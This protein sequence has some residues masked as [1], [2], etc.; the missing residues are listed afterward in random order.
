MKT[1]LTYTEMKQ[2]KAQAY[3]AYKARKK[4]AYDAF[5]LQ[6]EA[7]WVACRQG[8]ITDQMWDALIK[9]LES[10]VKEVNEA[11]GYRPIDLA[12]RFQS[13]RQRAQQL[14]A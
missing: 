10:L 14:V 3:A 2:I 8:K 11:Y 13:F 6:E 12:A 1:S 9:S 5:K 7:A 4:Q